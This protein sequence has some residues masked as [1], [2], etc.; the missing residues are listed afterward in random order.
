M[1][2]PVKCWKCGRTMEPVKTEGAVTT[3]RCECG[4]ETTQEPKH[5]A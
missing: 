4:E 5:E 3:Y 2:E 1:N